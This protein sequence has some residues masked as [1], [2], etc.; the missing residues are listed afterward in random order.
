MDIVLRS[1]ILHISLRNLPLR[2]YAIIHKN[3]PRLIFLPLCLLFLSFCSFFF[4]LSSVSFFFFFCILTLFCFFLWILQ[5]GSDSVIVWFNY[6][7][8]KLRMAQ[9]QLIVSN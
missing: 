1:V 5:V 2:Y 7:G 4:F 6:V 8:Q 3:P 9:S